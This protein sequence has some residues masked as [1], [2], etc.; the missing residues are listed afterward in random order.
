MILIGI[1]D[2]DNKQSRGTGFKARQLG[3]LIEKKKLGK[4]SSISRHQLFFDN[5][6]PYTSQNSSACLCIRNGNFEKLRE[7]AEEFLKR[8]SAPGSDAGLAVA[9]ADSINLSVINWGKRA[10]SE[11][12]TQREAIVIAESSNIFL[13]GYTG[14]KD[15]IIGSLAAIGLRKTGNDG[16]CI[17]VGG[18]ELRE[19]Q[20]KYTSEE[21]FNIIEIDNIIDIDNNHIHKNSIIDSGDWLRPV[22]INNKITVIT[23][24]VNN[25][26][27][28]EYKVANKDFIKSISD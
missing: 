6:I 27:N 13:E 15:G 7:L 10:K 19:L 14:N 18:V 12:L 11:V 21:L 22:I 16:R 2:T 8:E 5:R 25:K 17:W 23:E 24:K 3:A 26:L 1:D 4:V 20:G 9:Y 28:Y